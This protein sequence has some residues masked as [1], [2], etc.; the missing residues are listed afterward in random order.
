MNIKDMITSASI[1]WIKK[2]LDDVN[3]DWKVTFEALSNQLN[4]NLC[5]QRNFDVNE[6]DGTVLFDPYP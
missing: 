1:M 6:F 4:I 2:Y 3:R 5:I